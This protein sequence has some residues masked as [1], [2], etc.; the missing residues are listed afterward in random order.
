MS[1]VE[2]AQ[3]G[4]AFLVNVVFAWLCASLLAR[5][6]L[7]GTAL[8][9]LCVPVLARSNLISLCGAG[10]G[11]L[12]AMCAA[13]AAMAV[14]ELDQVHTVFI[15]A[16]VHTSLGRAYGIAMAALVLAAMACVLRMNT[17]ITVVL[18]TVFT[19]GRAQVSHAGGSGLFSAA[20]LADALHLMLIGVWLGSVWISAWVVMPSAGGEP[21]LNYM[22]S[23]SSAATVA[24]A[25]IVGTGLFGVWQR[26]DAP[27]RLADL[28]YGVVLSVKLALF[29]IAALLGAYNRFAGFPAS[30]RDGGAC[31]LRV[32]RIES[33]CLL[34]A[35]GAAAVLTMQQP[36][37]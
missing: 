11:A 24:L 5:R 29:A 1:A 30:T 22:A 26:L 16:V 33:L 13:F 2:V 12:A 15:E 31:A 21:P 32:L 9:D 34:S 37:A 23:L 27:A 4:S 17:L 8:A 3:A 18:L 35:L 36:P 20:M 28:P 25:G 10:L 7:D 6:W 19:L 14:V